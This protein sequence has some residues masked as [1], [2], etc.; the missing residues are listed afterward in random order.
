MELLAGAH[1]GATRVA[2]GRERL[3]CLDDRLAV[4]RVFGVLAAQVQFA[5]GVLSKAHTASL[6]DA[7]VTL[8]FAVLQRCPALCLLPGRMTAFSSRLGTVMRTAQ[9]AQRV[10]TVIVG[11]GLDVVDVGCECAA[12]DTRRQ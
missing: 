2:V 10:K 7:W 12:D 3:D 1:S 6:K 5:T 8:R 11:H 9:G 4:F